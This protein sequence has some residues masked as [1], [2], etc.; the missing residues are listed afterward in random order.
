MKTLKLQVFSPWFLAAI[1]VAILVAKVQTIRSH[2]G[3]PAIVTG[4]SLF[5]LMIFLALFNIRKRLAMLPLGSAALWLRL[6]V[7]GGI[8]VILFFWMHTGVLWPTG[9]YEQTLTALFYL[10][11][12]SGLIGYTLQRI[13]PS[14]LTH[15]N[16]EIIYERIPNELAEIRERAEGL[17]LNCTKETGNDTLAKHY[18]Q[19]LDWFFRRP[20]FFSSHVL[21]GQRGNHWIRHQCA[22]VRRYLNNVECAY[23]DKLAVLAETKNKIDIHYAVQS[24]LKG[25]LL[26][27]VP[28][29]IAVVALAVWHILLVHVYAL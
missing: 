22:T 12:L 25:W 3:N 2:L 7:V 24:I 5:S 28:L 10:L 9:L 26:V 21:G 8:L 1:A 23:L 13:Y 27:H 29:T 18:L 20:R 6:H 17:L 14:R 16:L 19:T 15:T 4:W 11:S